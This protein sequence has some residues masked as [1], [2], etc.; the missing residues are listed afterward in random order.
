MQHASIRELFDYWNARRGTKPMPERSDIEP[1][2]IR[3]LLA[4]TF[5][6]AV[7]AQA[8]HPF[9]IAGTRVCAAFGRELKGAAFTDLWAAASQAR[10]RDLLAAV[11]TEFVGVVAGA[12]GR[13]DDGAVLQLEM[14]ALPLAHRNRPHARVLGALVPRE[15]PYWLGV[16]TLGPLTLGMIRYLG[17][18]AD[19]RPA[20]RALPDA[21]PAVRVRHRLVV[22]DGRSLML[23]M[24]S[25]ARALSTDAS[26]SF[27]R[28]RLRLSHA[29]VR[30]TTQRRLRS[31]KPLDASKRR[32]N[33]DRPAGR[34]VKVQ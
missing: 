16:H 33:L 20:P 10:M 22:H 31:W 26:K 34:S 2:S 8:G 21:Q 18:E 9:R 13:S 30:S 14:L 25:Q 24:R 29:N 19:A 1:S 32:H 3:R 15:V 7:D 23:A 6:L 17:P 4:D 5:I 11:T 12:S 28:R 27:A